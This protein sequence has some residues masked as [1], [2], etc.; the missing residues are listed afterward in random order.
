[1]YGRHVQ[2]SLRSM[3]Q[4]VRF[5]IERRGPGATTGVAKSEEDSRLLLS[6]ENLSDIIDSPGDLLALEEIAID[7]GYVCLVA[8]WVPCAD[9]DTGSISKESV[10]VEREETSL[11]S[12]ARVSN[13]KRR[14][15]KAEKKL[16]KAQ[17]TSAVAAEGKHSPGADRNEGILNDVIILKQ[18]ICAT[19][20][21]MLTLCTVLHVRR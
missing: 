18:W 6:V 21:V 7:G 9:G 10:G 16:M 3:R 17:S 11:S 14:L 12:A 8:H 4:I 1:M 13:G 19:V 15:S 20:Y 5:I 2:L